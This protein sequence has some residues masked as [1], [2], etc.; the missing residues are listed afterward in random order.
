MKKPAIDETVVTVKKMIFYNNMQPG[1]E[2]S[3]R[4]ENSA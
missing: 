2:K 1:S 3:I 4:F